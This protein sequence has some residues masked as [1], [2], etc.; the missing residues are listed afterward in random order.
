MFWPQLPHI[1][2]G[3][4]HLLEV[5][6]MTLTISKRITLFDFSNYLIVR[7]AVFNYSLNMFWPQLPYSLKGCIH[8]LELINV[9]LTIS[10]RTNESF[11]QGYKA[12]LSKMA[13][14][15][16]TKQQKKLLE[17]LVAKG[18]SR[19]KITVM[20]SQVGEL[21]IDS[22]ELPWGPSNALQWVWLGNRTF[23]LAGPPAY[24]EVY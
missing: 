7:K 5:I 15:T 11:L 4:I 12:I 9:T 14:T 23:G 16:T 19:L 2:K 1:L 18:Y 6:N 10:K 20:R 3:C 17:A 13:T 21:N 22:F 8:L 24:C